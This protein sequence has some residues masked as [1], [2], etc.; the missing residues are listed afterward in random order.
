[1]QTPLLVQKNL[2]GFLYSVRMEGD[3]ANLLI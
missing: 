1:M 3:A 2:L